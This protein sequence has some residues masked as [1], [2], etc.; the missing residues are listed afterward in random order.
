LV[1]FLEEQNGG[2][3]GQRGWRILAIHA[4]R[5]SKGRFDQGEDLESR[6][7]IDHRED[8]GSEL[9]EQPMVGRIHELQTGE[10]LSIIIVEE[11]EGRRE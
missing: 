10:D 3:N 8:Q 5:D 9:K 11:I 4:S 6:L 2:G 7:L 1:N